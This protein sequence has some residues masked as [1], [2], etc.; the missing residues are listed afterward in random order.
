MVLHLKTYLLQQHLGHSFESS[1]HQLIAIL[2]D[3]MDT[4]GNFT[5]HFLDINNLFGNSACYSMVQSELHAES[6]V[7]C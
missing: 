5:Q 4:Q 7:L 3:L 6:L 1:P 2:K